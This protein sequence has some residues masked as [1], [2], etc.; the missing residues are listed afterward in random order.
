MNSNIAMPDYVDP[1]QFAWHRKSGILC[2]VYF[3]GERA[4]EYLKVLYVYASQRNVV[5]DEIGR[6]SCRERV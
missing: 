4:S 1:E 2:P 5:M 3:T 6:A